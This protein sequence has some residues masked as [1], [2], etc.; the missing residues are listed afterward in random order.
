VQV[1]GQLGA[2]WDIRRADARL[3]AYGVRR[4]PRSAHRRESSGWG[5]LTASESRIAELVGQGWS[6]PDIAAELYLSRRTVQT[7]VSHIL[8]KLQLH[9]RIEVVR[10]LAQHGGTVPVT[11]SNT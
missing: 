7:H 3:R 9:S 5:A 10:A 2:A 8:T 4:G 1:Y 11:S 6:N